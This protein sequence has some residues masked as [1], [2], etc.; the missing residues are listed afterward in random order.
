MARFPCP[1]ETPPLP[2]HAWFHQEVLPHESALRAYLR[3]RF[4]SLEDRDIIQESYL[5]LIRARERH[6]IVCHQSFLF[7]TARN[8]ALGLIRRRKSAPFEEC[9]DVGEMSLP[10]P[11]MTS[12][13][14]IPETVAE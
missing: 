11:A 14:P 5:R 1:D 7:I 4:S 12:P 13:K 9:E 6:A 3:S 8:L 2:A 10:E